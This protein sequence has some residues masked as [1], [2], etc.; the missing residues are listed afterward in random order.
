MSDKFREAM[1]EARQNDIR[2]EAAMHLRDRFAMAALT[3]LLARET[4][5]LA[6]TEDGTAYGDPWSVSALTAK[7][8][9]YADAMCEARVLKAKA[10][11]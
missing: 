10:P 9:E 8:Y 7:A 11:Q 4:G 6:V 1:E 3:G 2:R 5:V